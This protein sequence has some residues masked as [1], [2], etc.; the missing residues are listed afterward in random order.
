LPDS[1]IANKSQWRYLNETSV[2][3][4]N[5]SGRGRMISVSSR[6]AR[7][8]IKRRCLNKQKNTYF[9]FMCIKRWPA[10]LYVYRVGTLRGQKKTLDH[11]IGITNG[12]G[13]PYGVQFLCKNNDGAVVPTPSFGCF[14]VMFAFLPTNSSLFRSRHLTHSE[15]TR[16]LGQLL[17]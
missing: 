2:I 3:L 17:S 16:Y 7:V 8:T 14:I 9:C 4:K 10:C 13:L 5:F 12:C 6:T 11:V 15:F 1:G